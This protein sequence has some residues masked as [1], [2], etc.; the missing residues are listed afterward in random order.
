VQQVGAK[1]TYDMKLHSTSKL[2]SSLMFTDA[3]TYADTQSMVI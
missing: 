2:A 1:F 3:Y